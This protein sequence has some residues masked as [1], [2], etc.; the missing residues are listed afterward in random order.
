MKLR[1]LEVTVVVVLM[2]LSIETLI[3][4]LAFDLAWWVLIALHLGLGLILI[5][6][7]WIVVYY[8]PKGSSEGMFWSNVLLDIGCLIFAP[9]VLV[10]ILLFFAVILAPVRTSKVFPSITS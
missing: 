5:L 7:L 10:A 3:D 2:V 6:F 1:D 8:D 9:L 4:R